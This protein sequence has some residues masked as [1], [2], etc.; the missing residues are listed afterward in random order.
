MISSFEKSSFFTQEITIRNR[1]RNEELKY[2][3]YFYKTTRIIPENVIYRNPFIFFFV[4]CENYFKAKRFLKLIRSQLSN[5][6]ILIIRSETTLMKLLFSFFPDTYIHDIGL[7]VMEN[8]RHVIKILFLFYK[9]RGIAIGK[10]GTYIKILNEIF[11]DFV[12]I[13]S[14]KIP[15]RIKCE[16]IKK[17]EFETSLITL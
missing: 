15:I 17:K 6:K 11:E 4:K 7:S 1:Y 8:G 16:L 10:E 3:Y 14:K 5:K 9:D 12:R 13:D 2:Y